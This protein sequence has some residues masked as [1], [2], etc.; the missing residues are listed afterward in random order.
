MV[1]IRAGE[2]GHYFASSL[3]L[4]RRADRHQTNNAASS[5]FVCC[6]FAP[7]RLLLGVRSLRSVAALI[8]WEGR[9]TAPGPQNLLA[10]GAQR[11]LANYVEN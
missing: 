7:R 5:L 11:C 1:G 4:P 10:F 2:A 8:Y 6:L 9:S 3:I